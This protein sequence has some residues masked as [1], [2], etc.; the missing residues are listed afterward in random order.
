MSINGI[1]S[2]PLLP[3]LGANRAESARTQNAGQ[4]GL[5]RASL[6]TQQARTANANALKPQT[7]IAGQGAA[8]SIVPADAPAGTDPAFWS[9]LTTEE[10]NFFAKTANLGPLTYSRFKAAT[11]PQTPPAA[12]GVRLDVRA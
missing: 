1:N 9:V 10:R 7:P 5:D 6:A 12:R 11:E 8:Q 2:T 3:N 4:N